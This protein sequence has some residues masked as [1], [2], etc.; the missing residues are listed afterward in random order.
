MRRPCPELAGL[1]EGVQEAPPVQNRTGAIKAAR[2]MQAPTR[3]KVNAPVAEAE[4]LCFKVGPAI[5]R[6]IF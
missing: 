6:I 5:F 3:G 2:Q 4:K 1:L